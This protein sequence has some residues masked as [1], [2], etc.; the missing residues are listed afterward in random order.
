MCRF[1]GAAGNFLEQAISGERVHAGRGILGGRSGVAFYG[2]DKAVGAP[3]EL[4][5]VVQD[6]MN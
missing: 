3:K 1:L 2:V 4:L 5:T 6:T